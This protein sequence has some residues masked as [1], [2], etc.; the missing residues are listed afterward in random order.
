MVRDTRF[1]ESPDHRNDF[2]IDRGLILSNNVVTMVPSCRIHNEQIYSSANLAI[3]AFK[4]Y[5][6]LSFHG[7]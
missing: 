4:D 1:G 7:R 5:H 3:A 2:S 6:S